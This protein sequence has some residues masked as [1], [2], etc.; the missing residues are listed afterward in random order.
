MIGH[1]IHWR[2]M[3]AK[4]KL[5]GP[6][7]RPS[8]A[9]AACFQAA[10]AQWRSSQSRAPRALI[11]GVTPELFFLDWP[12]D[13]RL[14]ALDNSAEM[15]AELWPGTSGSAVLGSWTDAP[16]EAHSQDL[17][18]LDGGF[19]V[20]SHPEGQ[21]ALLGEIRRLLAPGGLFAVRLFAPVGRTGSLEAIGSDLGAGR[22]AS[23]DALKLRLWGAL[24]RDLQAGVRP[25]D[26]VEEIEALAGGNIHRLASAFGWSPEHVNT[27]ELHRQSDATYHLAGV[28]DLRYMLT[29][30]PGLKLRSVAIPQHE[31][32]ESCPVVTV[33]NLHHRYREKNQ[34]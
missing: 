32:G 34:R 16:L 8:P 5:V 10:I 9:D 15:I 6:P 25:R 12:A 11:L 33:Q 4:W 2:E 26:V 23:L 18:L 20:L 31:F 1:P 3:A 28:D 17:I 24:H 30:Q 22:V 7:L 14:T 27:L 21:H 19:G 13:T 29:T